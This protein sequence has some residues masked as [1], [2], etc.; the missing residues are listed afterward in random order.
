MQDGGRTDLAILSSV[1]WWQCGRRLGPLPPDPSS[2]NSSPSEA[3]D[4]RAPDSESGSR[5]TGGSGPPAARRS[6]ICSTLPAADRPLAQLALLGA[7]EP[8]LIV[9]GR[10]VVD[11]V[12]FLDG[13][14]VARPRAQTLQIHQLAQREDARLPAL[15]ERRLATRRDHRA[16]PVHAAQIVD[17]VHRPPTIA[18]WRATKDLEACTVAGAADDGGDSG[19]P[20]TEGIGKTALAVEC[21]YR[22]RTD[23]DIVWW[24]RA[25]DPGTLIGQCRRTPSHDQVTATIGATRET[26]ATGGAWAA[27]GD[28]PR[29]H[30][31][32]SRRPCGT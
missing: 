16:E 32:G 2:G 11:R 6:I 25:E 17:A 7:P 22:Y 24:V 20:G 30:M 3:T 10:Q 31:G 28:L 27:A 14:A 9:G 5:C 18:P 4:F 23:F 29:R 8:A 15:V 13:R 21:A 1:A 19:D 26:V 12:H